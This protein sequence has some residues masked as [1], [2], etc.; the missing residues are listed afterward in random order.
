MDPRIDRENTHALFGPAIRFGGSQL[1]E[2]ERRAAQLSVKTLH[3]RAIA[4]SERRQARAENI[5]AAGGTLDHLLMA[6]PVDSS[7]P[8]NW[9]EL[10]PKPLSPHVNNF[11]FRVAPFDYDWNWQ[12]PTDATVLLKPDGS[13]GRA[14]L[15]TEASPRTGHTLVEAHAGVGIALRTTWPAK[16]T[17]RCLRRIQVIYNVAGS[18]DAWALTEGGIELTILRDGVLVNAAQH[19]VFRARASAGDSMSDSFGF[20]GEP[21]PREL[22]CH[23]D[24]GPIYTFN[25][26]IW[27]RV[28]RHKTVLGDGG[29]NAF[30]DAFFDTMSVFKEFSFE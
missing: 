13:P 22:S 1:V 29:A 16:A 8:V 4:S 11:I 15:R 25:A 3:S 2:E 6:P 12:V 17:M 10:L 20:Y 7:Q 26:G 28:E 9:D 23:M 30:M 21:E 19:K 18:A 24:A 14:L 27:I 5:G